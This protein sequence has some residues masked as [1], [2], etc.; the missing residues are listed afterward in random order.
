MK[1]GYMKK[2][3]TPP[4]TCG[5]KTKAQCKDH[6]ENYCRIKLG[7]DLPTNKQDNT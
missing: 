6:N 3:G 5:C 7:Y 4:W 1:G 2:E